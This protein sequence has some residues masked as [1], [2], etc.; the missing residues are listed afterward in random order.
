MTDDQQQLQD[1]RRAFER[2]CHEA[3][4]RA[5]AGDADVRYDEICYSYTVCYLLRFPHAFA[6]VWLRDN[7][8]L[9]HSSGSNCR[10]SARLWSPGGWQEFLSGTIAK[11][12]LADHLEHVIAAVRFAT[13]P[14]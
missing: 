12:Q 10:F 3:F 5:V 1:E 8:R 9:P 14:T 4:K 6:G 7:A 11:A 13:T 2:L